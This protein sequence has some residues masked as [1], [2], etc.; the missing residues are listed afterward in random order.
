[1]TDDLQV[2]VFKDSA[3]YKPLC[4]SSPPDIELGL[5]TIHVVQGRASVMGRGGSLAPNP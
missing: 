5:E 2:L 4:V 1:M 3:S